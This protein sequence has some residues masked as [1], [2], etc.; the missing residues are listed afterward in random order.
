M[1]IHIQKSDYPIIVLLIFGMLSPVF[2]FLNLRTFLGITVISQ[3]APLAFAY[4]KLNGVEQYANKSSFEIHLKNGDVLKI[5]S[6]QELFGKF[7]GFYYKKSTYGA[8]ILYGSGFIFKQQG[9]LVDSTLHKGLCKNGPMAQ[10]LNLNSEISYARLDI[11]EKDNGPQRWI[12]ETH[13]AE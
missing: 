11:A 6:T 10:I 8:A 13:C 5:D 1:K 3:A 4:T 9:P 12:R 7:K 2:L